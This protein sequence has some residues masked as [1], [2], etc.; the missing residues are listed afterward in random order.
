[1][2]N[3]KCKIATM[4][5]IL[6]KMDYEISVHPKDDRWKEWKKEAK[7]F[8]KEGKRICY[9]GLLEKKIICE[10]TA[11]I[12]KEAAQNSEELIDEI[13]AYL[14]A[15]RTNER[16]RGKG[17]F[18]KLYRF[19][20]EDLRKRGYKKLTLGVEPEEKQN[21][22]IYQHLGFTKFIKEDYEEEPAKN[23]N[24]KPQKVLV[25]YYLKELSK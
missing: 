3:Y 10:I 9:V 24:G 1:M 22:E 21:L 7:K 15:F 23:K 6:E 2:K 5:E 17:Y 25:H 20:E 11:A 18:S 13:T 19:V 4:E 14:F 12:H 16:E 8:F